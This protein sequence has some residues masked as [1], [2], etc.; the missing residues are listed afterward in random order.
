MPF[1]VE[2]PSFP[3]VATVTSSDGILVG[4]F[5]GN[6]GVKLSA[7]FSGHGGAY[8]VLFFRDEAISVRSG[9]PAW[10]PDSFAVAYDF[11]SPIGVLHQWYAVAINKNGTVLH[12]SE[13]IL[14]LIPGVDAPQC[15]DPST[16]VWLKSIANLD[17]SMNFDLDSWLKISREERVQ[18]SRVPGRRN[19][20]SNWDLRGGISTSLT[21][22]TGTNVLTDAMEILLD[23]GPLLFQTQAGTLPHDFY[24]LPV[25]VDWSFSAYPRHPLAE[26]TVGLQEI[27]RPSTRYSPLIMPG[28][29]Y[30]DL[31]GVYQT[32][33]NL[34]AQQDSYK[35][36][37]GVA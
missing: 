24:C 23:S 19:P 16:S 25:S 12:T 36:L 3:P 10:A 1:I 8:Q 17:L 31:S 7:D 29:S 33:A 37:L 18:F 5:D 13:P 14:Y 35:S 11:E 26:W 34:A 20:A 15:G 9:D 28:L 21:F 27:P 6:S 22:T 4:R 2:I 32:Y 30:A